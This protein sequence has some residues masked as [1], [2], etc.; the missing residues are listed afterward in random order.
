MS[1]DTYRDTYYLWSM[2]NEDRSEARAQLIATSARS[3]VRAAPDCDISATAWLEE[4]GLDAFE[5]WT[6]DEMLS[7]FFLGRVHDLLRY[8]AELECECATCQGSGSINVMEPTWGA[9]ERWGSADCEE[10]GGHG[11]R[12]MSLVSEAEDARLFEAWIGPRAAT[13]LVEPARA[14]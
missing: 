11:E 3:F 14:A 9:E 4:L 12:P 1:V 8:A 7:P 2:S 6:S 13:V 10:C 5:L